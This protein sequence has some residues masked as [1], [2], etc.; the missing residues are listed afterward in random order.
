[1]AVNP[2]EMLKQL[3]D[4]QS[5]MGEIQEKLRTVRVTGSSG[6][7]LVMVEMNG[8]MEAEKVTIA[9]EA[10]DPRDVR[11]LEDLV[12]SALSDAMDRLKE[13]LKEEMSAFTGLNLPPGILGM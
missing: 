13:K 6:G 8:Q 4:I 2:F 12:L 7:G 10:V 11:M 1:V 3:Q 5:R 9:P